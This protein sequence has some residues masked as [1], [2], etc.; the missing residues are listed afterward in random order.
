MEMQ[1]VPVNCLFENQ[2]LEQ[3]LENFVYGFPFV[4]ATPA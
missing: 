3:Y 4:A 2:R 1:Q